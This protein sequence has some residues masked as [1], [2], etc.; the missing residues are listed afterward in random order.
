MVSPRCVR[1][2]I[3]SLLALLVALPVAAAPPEFETIQV[4]ESGTFGTCD[5]FDVLQEVTG[6]L[7][8]SR[9]TTQDGS[10]VEIVRVRLRE[11]FTNSVT[12]ESVSTPDVGIDKVTTSQDGTT[13]VVI[14]GLINRIVVPGEGLIVATAGRLVLVFS[15]PGAPDVVFEAGPEGELLPA[16]C[17]ALAA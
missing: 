16:L 17:T 14:I 10:V 7:K 13:T 9:R 5:G 2:V 15:G 1:V 3:A 11:T 4:N 8:I 12:G 6:T